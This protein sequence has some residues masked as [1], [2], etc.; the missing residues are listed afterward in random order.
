MIRAHEVP[1]FGFT[2]HFTNLCTTVFSCSHY[3]QNEN[4][5]AV[6]LVAHNQIRAIRIDTHNNAPATD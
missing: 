6:I 5:A 2:N 4:E 1:S 3:C